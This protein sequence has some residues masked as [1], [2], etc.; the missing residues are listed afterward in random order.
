MALAYTLLAGTIVLEVVGALATRW[1]DGFTRPLP[2]GVTVASITGAYWLFA[3]ALDSGLEIGVAYA[4]WAAVGMIAVAL[5]GAL[6]LDDRLTRTQ[7]AGGAL[8]LVG[9]LAL[10]LG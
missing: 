8:M 5:F 1:S 10:Q 4:V 3:L 7:T 6:V 9:V 2:T